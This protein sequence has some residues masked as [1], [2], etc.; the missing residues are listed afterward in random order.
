MSNAIDARASAMPR[1]LA[2]SSLSYLTLVVLILL[3]RTVL[4]HAATGPILSDPGPRQPPKFGNYVEQPPSTGEIP[5]TPP[6]QFTGGVVVPVKDA[7]MVDDALVPAIDPNPGVQLS[8]GHGVVGPGASGPA[9]GGDATDPDPPLD[10]FIFAET[11]P[12]PVTRVTP[13][14]PSIARQAGMEGDVLLAM[15]VGIDGHVRRVTVVQSN[16]LF[17]SAALQAARQC[18]FTPATSN[19]HPVVVW[20]HQALHFTLHE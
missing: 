6:T 7:P 12:E 10:K 19:H 15:Q 9:G 18:V 13:E 3:A 8:D 11:L 14:Y 20:V 4:P 17:D 1:S 5:S 2:Y 16:V